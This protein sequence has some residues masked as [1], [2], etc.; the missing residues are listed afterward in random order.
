MAA[1]ARRPGHPPGT[2]GPRRVPHRS[3]CGRGDGSA[4]STGL[5]RRMGR[6][7]GVA[8]PDC[9]RDL[10]GALRAHYGAGPGPRGNASAPAPDPARGGS[11]LGGDYFP[12]PALDD[13]ERGGGDSGRDAGRRW[14]SALEAGTT[15]LG[16][17]ARRWASYRRRPILRCPRLIAVFGHQSRRAA[18]V[19]GAA[20]A[21]SPF[22]TA[23]GPD[24]AP[25]ASVCQSADGGGSGGLDPAA[26]PAPATASDRGRSRPLRYCLSCRSL[27]ASRC[28]L[29]P[30][31]PVAG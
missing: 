10:P 21:G 7:R 11:L 31:S 23:I 25:A 13:R 2:R 6:R 22:T 26:P 15:H 4:S 3:H 18:A 24:R 8:G 9:G 30:T 16:A 14:D 12:L 20:S 1:D 29:W 19:A 27:S 5:R 28:A 17:R